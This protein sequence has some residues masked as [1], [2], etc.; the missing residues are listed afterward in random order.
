MRID[1]QTVGRC[2][3]RAQKFLNPDADKRRLDGFVRIGVDETS[4]RKGHKYMTVVNHDTSEVVRVDENHGRSVFEKFFEDLTEEQ[5]ASI[6]YV[7]GDGARWIDDCLRQYAP[8]A[9]RCFEPFHVVQWAGQS[10]DKL[11]TLIWQAMR[12]NKRDLNKLIKQSPDAGKVKELKAKHNETEAIAKSVKGSIY[13]LGK[14]P[15]NLTHLQA[16]RLRLIAEA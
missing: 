14:A 5:R 7:S 15:E 6:R 3:E 8:Q 9:T 2:V 10:I 1:W 11:R 13:A 12:A 16:E 4:Y